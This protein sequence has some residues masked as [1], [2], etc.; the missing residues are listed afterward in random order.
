MNHM[1][2]VEI[3]E[4]GTPDRVRRFSRGRTEVLNLRGGTVV[5]FVFEPGWRWSEDVKPI[6]GTELCE[7]A[8]IHYH[9]AGTL[10]IRMADGSEF[11]AL[12][13]QVTTVPPGHDAWVQ[14]NEQVIVIDWRGAGDP[15]SR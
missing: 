4:F 1:A 3:R 5:R 7:I 2:D 9:V 11:V 12:P 6:M 15:S 14:G 10:G 13:G 8:H